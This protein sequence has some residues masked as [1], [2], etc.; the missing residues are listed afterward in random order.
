MH[1]Y[2][3]GECCLTMLAPRRVPLL[4]VTAHCRLQSRD[5][6]SARQQPGSLNRPARRDSTRG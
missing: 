4:E 1:P 3:L 2:G 6:V 5:A